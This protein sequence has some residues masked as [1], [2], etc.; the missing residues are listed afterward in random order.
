[1]LG[2]PLPLTIHL[3]GESRTKESQERLDIEQ[4]EWNNKLVVSNP[5]FKPYRCVMCIIVL[6]LWLLWWSLLIHSPC[7]GPTYDVQYRTLIIVVYMCSITPDSIFH[8]WWLLHRRGIQTELAK[9]GPKAST[10]LN[11]LSGLL[12][13]SPIKHS[14]KQAGLTV[15]DI[16]ALDVLHNPQMVNPS[17][18]QPKDDLCK[19]GYVPGPEISRSLTLSS[20][21]IPLTTYPHN[22]CNG[23]VKHPQNFRW[24]SAYYVFC[25]L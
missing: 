10:Q 21:V 20:N 3:A 18:G 5:R 23:I 17:N 15:H 22:S 2:L 11:K 16:P 9:S 4:T 12:K 25:L 19:K 24:D 13:D 6:A 7:Q 8:F 14:L 1:M